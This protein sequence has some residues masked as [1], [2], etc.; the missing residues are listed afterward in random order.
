MAHQATGQSVRE[1]KRSEVS[2]SLLGVEVL[3]R[4]IGCGP[5]QQFD[6]PVALL[7]RI[8]NATRTYLRAVCKLANSAKLQL[9]G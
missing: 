2:K 1:S 9:H 5:F 4:A 7:V 8:L 6:R 3:I